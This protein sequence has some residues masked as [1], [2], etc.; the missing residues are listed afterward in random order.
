MKNTA[1]LRS[2]ITRTV[3]GTCLILLV[4]LVAMQF[5]EQVNWTILDFVV[6]GCLLLGAG[7]T[8]QLATRKTQDTKRRVI[9]GAVVLV[10]LLAVWAQ[11][12]VGIFN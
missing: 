6:A 7:F 1:V 2:P 8:Y 3:L 10:V 4:P 11:L 9:I 12:A 5:S